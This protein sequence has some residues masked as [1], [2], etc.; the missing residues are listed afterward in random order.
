V[1]GLL[2]QIIEGSA[3]MVITTTSNTYPGGDGRRL[4]MSGCFETT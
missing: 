2:G 3:T 4:V 1:K